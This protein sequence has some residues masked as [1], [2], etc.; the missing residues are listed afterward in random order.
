MDIGC[1]PAGIAIDMKSNHLYWADYMN[2]GLFRLYLD[3]SNR[4]EKLTDLVF[5]QAIALDTVNK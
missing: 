1:C 4:T 5:S 3:G 2:W